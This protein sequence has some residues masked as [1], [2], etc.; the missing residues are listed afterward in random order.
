VYGI[1]DG[2]AAAEKVAKKLTDDGIPAQATT[3]LPRGE[4]WSK[5]LDK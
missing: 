5:I 3:T 2:K 4:Y 1:F